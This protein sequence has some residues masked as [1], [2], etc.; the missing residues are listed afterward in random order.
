MFGSKNLF[1]FQ[2]LDKLKNHRANLRLILKIKGRSEKDIKEYL[3][4]YDFFAA[5]PRKYD[6]ATIVKD[7]V[8]IR[9]GKFYL[10]LDAMLHD[11]E[12]IKGSKHFFKTKWECDRKYIRNMELN[13]KGI[14]VTRLLFL[15]I[16]AIYFPIIHYIKLKLFKK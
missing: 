16:L 14:R 4:A 6:G 3:V 15:T 11:Y 13:G 10:D 7:L 12:Y 1:F 2:G 5:N 9:S 8:D